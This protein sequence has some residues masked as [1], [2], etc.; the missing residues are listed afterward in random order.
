MTLPSAI[1]RPFRPQRGFT[2]VEL[3]ITIVV[4]AILLAVAMPSFRD[5]IQG[6]RIRL[7]T[8]DLYASLV[9]ARSEAIKRNVT[10]TVTATGGNWQNGWTVQA[11]GTT[12]QTQD[13]PSSV[14]VTG[15]VDPVSY[16][17][18]G[19]IFATLPPT[20]TISATGT[21][22]QARCITIGLSGIPQIKVDTDGDAANGC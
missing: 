17:Y 16:A 8:S 22:S 21:N 5:L 13:A 1:A 12:I 10:A 11:S 7:T 4:F 20:F 3:M 2:L 19:R 6:Q 15:P 14:T 9:M 18:T